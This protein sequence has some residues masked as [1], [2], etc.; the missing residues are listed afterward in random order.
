MSFL[1]ARHVRFSP[2]TYPLSYPTYLVPSLVIPT[3]LNCN[4][5]H[6]RFCRRSHHTWCV[7]AESTPPVFVDADI[8]SV[9]I[10]TFLAHS[11]RKGIKLK[12]GDKSEQAWDDL[13]YD[14]CVP[15][16]CPSLCGLSTIPPELSI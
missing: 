8:R 7:F 12:D 15:S 3:I 14:E 5:S 9:V 11:K 4:A 2:T 13:F 1:C 6:D 10:K 16:P